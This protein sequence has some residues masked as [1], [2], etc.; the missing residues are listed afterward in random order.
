MPIHYDL[1]VFEKYVEKYAKEE[2]STGQIVFYG[3]S[4]FT[5]WGSDWGH[6]P[7]RED[8]LGAS[9]A[10]CCI[11]RGFGGS[12]PEHQ[13]YYYNTFVKPLAPKVLVY[14]SWGNIRYLGYTN[15][16]AIELAERVVA[17]A[18]EK[19]VKACF[20]NVEFPQF[21]LRALFDH[22]RSKGYPSLGWT[23]DVGHA[24]CYPA[25]DFDVA[26]HFG[27]LLV[28]TH[29]HDNFGQADPHVI[30]WNDDS[31][32]LPFDGTVDFRRVGA[33]LKRCRYTG[34]ITLETGRKPM[35][36]WYRDMKIDEFLHMAHERAMHIAAWC[37]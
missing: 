11:N 14:G 31:H 5:R 19:G 6:R 28:G 13:L 24:H 17:Y 26:E 1:K 30:T 21:E 9:G 10:P 16:E 2:V 33:S 15:E 8:L 3:P 23:W 22:L 18:A 7:L 12:C 27:D 35:I 29:M 20:E 36:P 25:P 37:E 32:V 4:Y 34:T